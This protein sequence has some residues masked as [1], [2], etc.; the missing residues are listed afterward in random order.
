MMNWNMDA[1]EAARG[2][3]QEVSDTVDAITRKAAQLESL[4]ALLALNAAADA[5]IF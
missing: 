2:A 3:L 5:Q 4:L 1:I